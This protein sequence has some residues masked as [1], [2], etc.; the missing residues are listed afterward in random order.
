[1]FQYIFLSRYFTVDVSY[2]DEP[3]LRHRDVQGRFTLLHLQT[4]QAFLQPR[5]IDSLHALEVSGMVDQTGFHEF[6]TFTHA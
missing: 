4:V 6:P 5:L 2:L 1:M 3:D